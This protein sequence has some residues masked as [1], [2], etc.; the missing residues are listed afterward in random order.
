MQYYLRDGY[1]WRKKMLIVAIRFIIK[2]PQCIEV[3]GKPE[4]LILKNQNSSLLLL[5]LRLN[6]LQKNIVA[7]LRDH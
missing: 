3:D 1:K 6:Q 5:N 2:I 7:H 4:L